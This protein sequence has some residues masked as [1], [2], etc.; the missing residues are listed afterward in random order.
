[1]HARSIFRDDHTL[2][3]DQVQRFIEAH[4]APH[5][6]QWERDGITP[7][8]LWREAG[9]AGLLNCQLPDPYGVGGD[10]GH[11]AC[12]IE[13]LA[14]ANYLGIGFSIHS[15]MVAPYLMQYGSDA[16]R[17][18]W[19]PAM[20][21]GE[22]IGAIAMTEP[23]AGSD[24]KAIRTRAERRG[25]HYVLNGQKTWITNGAHADVVVV[26]A[27]VAPELGARGLTLLCVDAHLPGITRSAPMAKI[28]QHAQDTTELFFQDVEVPVSHLLGE[29]QRG[30]DYLGEQLAAE[31]LAIA[32]RAAA[33]AEG[34]LAETV[35]YV[36]QRKAFGRF[37]IDHQNTRFV[38]ADAA[39]RLAMLR[40]FL[41]QCLGEQMEGRLDATRAAM[42]KLNATELQ[43]QVLDDLLQLHGGYGY[44]SEYGIGRAWAD[45]RALRIFGGTS[46]ILREIIGRAL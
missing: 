30:F 16:L 38:L 34:M 7:R 29:E 32:L 10:Y 14:R 8:A 12:V 2:F 18:A 43:G 19:L 15:D 20:A 31:R 37:L 13:E 36:R 28:G 26:V 9:E 40:T 44:S 24:L 25:D 11:A 5:Y 21:R 1:M 6:A 17:D 41:D 4:I 33:S 45:A 27:T 22:A 35:A 3:R 23:G 46:E 42:A 39:A